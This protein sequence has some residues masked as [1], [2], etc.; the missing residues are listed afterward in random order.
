MKKET[1]R[2]KFLC[3]AGTMFLLGAYSCRKENLPDVKKKAA[4]YS[5][6][7]H[8]H[9]ITDAETENI[10]KDTEPLLADIGLATVV[11]IINVDSYEHPGGSPFQVWVD[12]K[13][14]DSFEIYDMHADFFPDTSEQR[15]RIVKDLKVG[16][17]FMMKGEYNISKD[18][19]VSL[20]E[21]TYSRVG[22]ENLENKMKKLFQIIEDSSKIKIRCGVEYI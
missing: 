5:K 8:R 13:A 6:D 21:P 2:R 10:F 22:P 20:Y 4:I 11:K 7:L 1:T 9:K 19:P 18:F 15:D 14:M 3:D 17:V 16:S 12:C